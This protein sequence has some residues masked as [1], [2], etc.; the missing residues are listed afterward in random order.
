MKDD[1]AKYLREC[2]QCILRK[3]TGLRLQYPLQQHQPMS[4]PFEKIYMDL[5]EVPG[6]KLLVI[7]D[8]FSRWPEALEVSNH[9]TSTEIVATFIKAF[10]N[11]FGAPKEIVVDNESILVSEFSAATMK[12]LETK[13][14]RISAQHP[15]SNALVE[16]L[17]RSLLDMLATYVNSKTDDWRKYLDACLFAYRTSVHPGTGL[18]PYEIVFGRLPRTP[19]DILLQRDFP[20][21]TPLKWR[22]YMADYLR[23][24]HIFIKQHFEDHYER[25]TAMSANPLHIG[26]KV[27]LRVDPTLTKGRRKLQPRFI[28]PFTVSGIASPVSVYLRDG[29]AR[30]FDT[31]VHLSQLVKLHPDIVMPT[32]TSHKKRKKPVTAKTQSIPRDSVEFEVDRLLERKR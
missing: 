31:P 13:L 11:R 4:R 1:L 30:C 9:P 29:Q 5:L 22:E 19:I 32:R 12:F 16:R 21:E 3:S 2:Q 17:N 23:E 28:G 25:E 10:Y 15:E 18:C 27:K 7:I 14:I 6:G 26:D 20:A 24:V 8:A